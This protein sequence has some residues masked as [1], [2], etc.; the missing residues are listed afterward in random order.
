MQDCNLSVTLDIQQLTDGASFRKLLVKESAFQVF[1]EESAV[2]NQ[3]VF[4]DT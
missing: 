4:D 2:N 3:V 1:V